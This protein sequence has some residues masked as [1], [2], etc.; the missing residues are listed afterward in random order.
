VGLP[1]RIKQLGA[2]I[3]E[4]VMIEP[5]LIPRITREVDKRFEEQIQTTLR[6]AAIP[7]TRGAEG[8]AQDLIADLLRK[9]A[10]SVDD[11]RIE[12]DAIRDLPDFGQPEHDFS[13]A[14]TV[15]GTM[16]PEQET[17]R[18]LILQGHCDVVPAGPL[19][20]WDTPPFKPTIKDGWLYGRGANDMKS[21]TI[22]ALYAVDAIRHAGL[23]IKGRI[24]F[25]SVIEEESTGVG[26]LSTLQRGYRAD[27]ALLP[28][29]T[30]QRFNG[31]CVGVIWFRLKVRG[32]PT[33]VAVAGEGSNAI[34]A[35][36]LLIQGLESLEKEWNERAA[37]DPHYGAVHHPINFNPGIIKG[38]DWASSVPAWCDVDC[39]IAL[40]PGWDVDSCRREI[41]ACVAKTAR[42]HTFLAN[43]PP[44]IVWSGYLSHGYVMQDDPEIL[45]VLESA[46]RASTQKPFQRRIST[47]L[48]DSRFYGLYYGIPAFC[49][50]PT[51]EKS[52]GFNERVNI[53][54]I[55][56]TTKAIAI[57]VATWCGVNAD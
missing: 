43:N 8:P 5:S 39:R 53:E 54:S 21:G 38:G 3:E 37:S 36:Y 22:A 33:H 17:G 57:F 30:G 26:A 13:Q 41:E 28:E 49:Y 48:N 40:L 31:I 18:S 10:Y 27:C 7:S 19:E 14:R 46:H 6:L 50:G 9:R 29:P 47:A 16:R 44:S 12:I 1:G 32:E 24:H 34:K 42:A 25:Q 45:R 15:V 2:K 51:G 35:A 11:W 20:M 55:Q 23:Q 4:R 56:E 52:H